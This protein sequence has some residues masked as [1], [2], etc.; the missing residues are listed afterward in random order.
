MLFL[1]RSADRFSDLEP[2]D[3]Q[4]GERE[5]PCPTSGRDSGADAALWLA[6]Y[7][8]NHRELSRAGLGL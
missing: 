1:S 2:A 4:G 5:D 6:V 8:E 3:V 7:E